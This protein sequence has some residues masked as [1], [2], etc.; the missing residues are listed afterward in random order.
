MKRTSL[1]DIEKRVEALT[2]AEKLCL[3]EN[4]AKTIRKSQQPLQITRQDIESMAL[5]RQIQAELR[6][7]DNEFRKTET[8]GLEDL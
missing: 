7:I 2:F 5:D 6:Q 1:K 8:D 4:L 3:L